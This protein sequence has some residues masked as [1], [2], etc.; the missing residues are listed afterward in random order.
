M[1][2]EEDLLK[3]YFKEY[4]KPVKEDPTVVSIIYLIKRK[5]KKSRN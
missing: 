2:K 3:D 4:K 1:R 5:E